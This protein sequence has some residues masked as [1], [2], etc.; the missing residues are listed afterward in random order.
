MNYR[1]RIIEEVHQHA[2]LEKRLGKVIGQFSNEQESIPL[3][4]IE[5]WVE[6]DKRKKRETRN[7]RVSVVA[8]VLL[9]LCIGLGAG[10]FVYVEIPEAIA[11]KNVEKMETGTDHKT[12]VKANDDGNENI[13]NSVEVYT[14]LEDVSRAQGKHPDLRVPV[15][16]PNG[17]AF[18]EL[19]IHHGSVRK[20]YEFTYAEEENQLTIIEEPE[21]NISVVEEYSER[22]K[23]ALGNTVY[24]REDEG[25]LLSF[26]YI[27]NTAITVIGNGVDHM[28]IINGMEKSQD[29]D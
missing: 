29:T 11:K 6:E 22:K 9:I 4:E 27:S 1:K 5:G 20:F 7:R 2:E 14:T 13:G 17:Y 15:G 23:T 26:V 16:I 18:K 12:I 8:C 24:M 3:S 25:I 10:Y 19:L 21:M 28:K